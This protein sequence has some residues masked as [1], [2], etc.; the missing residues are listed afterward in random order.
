MTQKASIRREKKNSELEP[1]NLLS[2]KIKLS[3]KRSLEQ[4]IHKNAIE[5]L[6]G[7]KSSRRHASLQ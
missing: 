6:P 7:H 5:E 3:K 2:T 1:D 4:D